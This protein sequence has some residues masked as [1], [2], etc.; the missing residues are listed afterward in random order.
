[1]KQ[2]VTGTL[3]EA[4]WDP[5]FRIVWGTI[6]GD[7]HGRFR[8]GSRI[9]TSQVIHPSGRGK[10]EYITTLNSYYKMEWAEASRKPVEALG[11]G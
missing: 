7:I 6:E 10:P 5:Y 2:T 1:M 8:D 11:I 9:H 4:V 3:K